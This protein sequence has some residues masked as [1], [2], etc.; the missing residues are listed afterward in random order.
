M[1]ITWRKQPNEKG[2]SRVCQSPRGAILRVD[3]RDVARVQAHRTDWQHYR[4]WTWY[5]RCDEL[6]VALLNDGRVHMTIEDAKAA[7]EAYVRACLESRK[8]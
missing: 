5:A 8:A 4:G 6:G 2:L 7:A 1:R 3:G